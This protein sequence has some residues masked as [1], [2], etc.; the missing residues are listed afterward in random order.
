MTPRTWRGRVFIGTSVDGKIAR[1][2]G[3]LDWL[4]D[5]SPR[6]H[7]VATHNER[8][9]LVWETFFPQT[10]AIVMGRGTYDSVLEFEEWP[11][12]DKTVIVL[13]TRPD[14]TDERVSTAGSV[15]AAAHL[16]TERNARDVY[17]DGGR[18]IRSFLEEDLIDEVTI[19]IAPVI[20]GSGRPLFGA[21]DADVL[22]TLRGTH[23][24]D[25]GLVRITYAVERRA[26]APSSPGH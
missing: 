1:T 12:A 9:A 8:P 10:D 16:L 18:T 7:E 11:F 17:V 13:T 21:L 19:S 2:D 14:I 20:L 4:T 6:G 5:L 15:E 23:A 26:E 25:D 24:T 3:T 22:L